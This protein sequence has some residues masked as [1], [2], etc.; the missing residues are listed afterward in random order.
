M[1]DLFE[2]FWS[3]PSSK[4]RDFEVGIRNLNPSHITQ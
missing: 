4:V 2:T 1:A 3:G